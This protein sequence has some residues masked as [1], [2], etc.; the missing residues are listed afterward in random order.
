MAKTNQFLLMIET[1]KAAAAHFKQ[2]ML[3][4]PMGP[5]TDQTRDDPL[6]HASNTEFQK[7]WSEQESREFAP[8]KGL[9]DWMKIPEEAA[10]ATGAS[11]L[12]SLLSKGASAEMP[13]L[14]ALLGEKGGLAGMAGGATGAAL[15]GVPG[16]I[17]G[18]ELGKAVDFGHE[19]GVQSDPGGAQT[20]M[21]GTP[22]GPQG[23]LG[24]ETVKFLR[25]IDSNIRGIYNDGIK[26]REAA[27][28]FGMKV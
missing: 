19:V 15:G 14:G 18:S 5:G 24:D 10:E 7:Y 9:E 23:Q 13:M 20:L 16:A 8:A 2:I 26:L 6:Y 3:E 22:V 11:S 25:S 4:M 1:D 28:R 12:A 21:A 27:A 17:V